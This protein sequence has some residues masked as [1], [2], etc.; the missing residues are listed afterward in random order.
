MHVEI[1]F[2]PVMSISIFDRH[3]VVKNRAGAPRF[4][5]RSRGAFQHIGYQVRYTEALKNYPKM[6][7]SFDG[8]SHSAYC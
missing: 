5:G 1:D 8:L 4:D 7:I 3:H 2:S 6:V